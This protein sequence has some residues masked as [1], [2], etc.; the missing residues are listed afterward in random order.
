MPQPINDAAWQF[1]HSVQCNAPRNFAWSYWTNIANWED[2]PA[3]FALD[4]PFDIGS[5]LTTLLPSQTFHSIIRACK[6]G[7]EATIEM[8]LPDAILSFH[9][10]FEELPQNHT[11]ITQRLVLSGPSAN[12]FVA[13]ASIFEQTAPAG[14]K[15]LAA[16]IERAHHRLQKASRRPS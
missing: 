7:R 14:M 11:R 6:A 2:P 8:E 9:W 3:K 12:S 15:K 5:R 16:A 10:Q 1:Q 13:Q 4:G